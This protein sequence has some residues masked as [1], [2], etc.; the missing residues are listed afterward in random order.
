MHF[1]WVQSP[2]QRPRRPVGPLL[3]AFALGG[4]E[5][6]DGLARL[7]G[8]LLVE[9]SALDFGRVS[10]GTSAERA[11]TLENTGLVTVELLS[12][13]VS[14]PYEVSEGSVL[15]APGGAV[16]RSVR[17][18]PVEVGAREAVLRIR[19]D[20][21]EAPAI[22]VPLTGAGIEASV[23][24]EPAVV[25]F[26]E[27]MRG[28]DPPP[29]R[30]VR[31]ENRGTEAFDLSAL[32]L[33][34]DA[35][36]VFALHPLDA[37]GRFE[38]GETRTFEVTFRPRT[39]SASEGA[40]RLTTT[41]PDG[42]AVEVVLQGQGVG[43]KMEV[44][45]AGGNALE[46]CTDRGETPSV[47]FDTA[48]LGQRATGWVRVKNVGDRQ[49]TVDAA[50]LGM[51][52]PELGFAPDP[53]TDRRFFLTPGAER[54]IEVGYAPTDLDFD[55]VNLAFSSDDPERPSQ[56]VLVRGEVP[57]PRVGVVPN[58][59]TFDLRGAERSE[60]S[61]PL[62]ILNCGTLPLR[63]EAS[64]AVRPSNGAFVIRGLPTA[65]EEIA[66]GDCTPSAPSLALEVVFAP[67]ALGDFRGELDITTSDPR[68]GLV[69]VELF[70]VFR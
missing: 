42:L 27:V 24:V 58:R 45:A 56:E 69:T 20:D 7:E 55:A 16:S 41:A 32:T 57:R 60:T 63:L 15:L 64:P 6:G 29:T 68:D 48:A 26:G 9:P 66:P 70:G 61:A 17:F 47:R 46:L 10:V 65:G 31:V 53:R 22:D 8:A 59:M 50:L 52:S 11:L 54:R 1:N 49:L 25:D 14:D 38:E 4:C 43:P 62:L 12:F 35:E 44:C 30:T 34:E 2:G 51:G 28:T 39:R 67:T 3:A 19:S 23:L 40:V 33:F 13:E 37:L 36:G 21:A 5:C 18:A